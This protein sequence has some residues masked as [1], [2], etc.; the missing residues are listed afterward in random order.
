ML[1][2]VTDDLPFLVDSV[3]MEVLRQGWTIREVFHPQFLVLRDAG[4]RLSHL[5]RSAQAADE[6]ATLHESWM[7]LDCCRPPGWVP[8]TPPRRPWSAASTR[9]S[10]SSG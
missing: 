5:L 6:P 2:V 1:Q 4:G 7:H 3:T 10:T 8:R 9:S